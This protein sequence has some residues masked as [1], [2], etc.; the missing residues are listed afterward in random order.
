MERAAAP[1]VLFPLLASGR[2]DRG[3]NHHGGGNRNG[4]GC[5]SSRDRGGRESLL[6]RHDNVHNNVALE[7]EEDVLEKRAN[8]SEENGCA[9]YC[10]VEEAFGLRLNCGYIY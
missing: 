7:D 3:R 9:G 4:G 5:D 1:R 6:N 10:G 8:L 2:S